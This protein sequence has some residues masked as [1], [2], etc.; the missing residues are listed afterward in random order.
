MG[1]VNKIKKLEKTMAELGAAEDFEIA[2]NRFEKASKLVKELLVEGD[3]EQGKVYE[4]IKE[5][6]NLIEIESDIE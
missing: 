1:E 3:K 4:V 6:D 2:S 5:L